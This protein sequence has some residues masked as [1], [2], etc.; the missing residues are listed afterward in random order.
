MT[1]LAINPDDIRAAL[2][3]FVE[4]Y[5]PETEREEVGHVTDT[6]DGIARVEGLHAT[7]TNELL[8]FP[9]GVRGLALNLDEREIGVVLLGDGTEIEEGSEVRR[10]GEVLAVPVGDGFLGRV[11]DALGNPIDGKGPVE[12]TERR[13]LELQAP[14]VVQ[15]QPVKEP[16]QTGIK[17]ID[18]MTAIGRGQRQLIIGDR[19]TGK[20]AV[21][22]DAIIN[23]RENWATGDPKKQVKC[24]YVAIGQKGSTIAGIVGR[25]QET[26][27]LD[28]TTV[29]AAPAD[30]PA[31]LKYLSPYT[32]SA[33]GQ[34]WMYA[35]Q[36]VLIVFDDLSKQ[37]EAYRTVSLLLRRPPG[38]EA[39]PGDVFYLHSRLLERCAKLSDDLGAGSMTGL[40]IIE[41]KGNDV[42]AY[43][44]TNVISITDGQCFLET[45]LFNAGV[46]PAINVGISVSRVGGSAQTKAMKKV[47][48]SLRLDLAQFRELEAFSAFASDL[49]KAS[50]ASGWSSCSSR[51]SIRRSPWSARWCRSGSAPRGGSTTC[52]CRRCGASRPGSWTTCSASA[53]ASTPPSPGP[54]SSRTRPWTSSRRRSP[55]SRHPSRPPPVSRSSRTSRWARW[56]ARRARRGSSAISDPPTMRPTTTPTTTPTSTQ[57]VTSPTS[58]RMPESLRALRGRIRSVR[59]TKKITKASELIAA[60]RIVKAQNAVA[61]SK[62]YA[63]EITRV[64]TAVTSQTSIDHPL[65]SEKGDAGEAAVLLITSDRGLAG[66]YSANA[67]RLCEQLQETLRS[68]GK[69]SRIYI[70]G[71]KGLSFYAFRQ[72][73]VEDSFTGFSE[74]PR[75]SD[76]KRAADALIQR[77]VTPTA[78]GGVDEIHMVFT[79]YVSALSQRPTA[80]RV[81]PLVIT[82]T[83][84]SPAEGPLPLYEFE[85][86]AE[87]VLDALLPRYVEARVYAALLESAASE[88]ASRRRA[89]KSASD[90]ADD[91]IRSY[92]RQANQVRQAAITQEISE[93]VGGANA[94]ADA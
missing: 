48:G 7:M 9:G 64:L 43:I 63:D 67:I 20:T 94:L 30:A 5:R 27:A 19:Q 91:L 70:I 65:T 87:A 8:E 81:L 76:A 11:V 60:S 34:H 79:E 68:E 58:T 85:P 75:Y 52:R 36:H 42:S 21:A 6:G 90:N 74:Q 14:T 89:M 22:I 54:G 72:R 13:P 37:A 83:S 50:A 51:R 4:G 88:S 35:G 93:I 49:D 61:A 23:Q 28:Y 41:T 78:E 45:D 32:G 86:S 53:R 73:E 47:A 80:T 38:R 16:L 57:P 31:G 62:P 15:R 82:E 29:V 17:A 55:T 3:E 77:F 44:P 39:Y 33:I 40:P 92:T 46:R 18:A 59:S 69:T 71:R 24:V 2:R 84:E 56:R 66:A 12:T 10:T 25:L 26:G 1:E